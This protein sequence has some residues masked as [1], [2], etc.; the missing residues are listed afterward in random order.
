MPIDKLFSMNNDLI[1]GNKM[2][3]RNLLPL[4]LAGSMIVACGETM[5]ANDAP[6][7]AENGLETLDAKA[8]SFAVRPGSPEAEAVV[9]FANQALADNAAGTA[10]RDLLDSEMHKTAAK[11]VAKFRAG[12]DGNFGTAD[13]KTFAD[14][15]ALDKVPYVGRTALMQMLGLADAAGYLNRTSVDCANYIEHDA[16]NNYYIRS[17]AAMLE[18]ENSRCSTITGNLTIQI[19]GTDILPPSAR[20]I[21]ALQHLESVT[22]NVL[23]YPTSIFNSI[24]FKSLKTIT[25]S[26]ISTYN[27]TPMHTLEFPALTGVSYIQLTGMKKNTFA[28]LETCNEISLEN[29]AMEGFTA[30]KAAGNLTMRVTSNGAY[31]VNFP[32]LTEATNIDF[33]HQPQSSYGINIAEFNGSFAKLANVSGLSMTKGSYTDL[34]FPKLTKVEGSLNTSSAKNPYDGMTKLD[35]VN[36]LS[37]QNDEFTSLINAGPKVLTSAGQLA[38]TSR[39]AVDGFEKLKTVEGD[40]AVNANSGISGF[41]ALETVGGSVS[42]TT[43]GGASSK[44]GGFNKLS[45]LSRLTINAQNYAV[46]LEPSFAALENIE[47]YLSITNNRGFNTDIQFA[48]LLSV[49]GGVRIDQLVG[50]RDVFPQLEIIDGSLELNYAPNTF[51]GMDKLTHVEGNLSI[52]GALS[53]MNGLSKLD[54]IG[55][56]L[57][58]PRGFNGAN[59]DAFL[60][61]LTEFS[62]TITFR[63]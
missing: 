47:S 24:N 45:N 17:Y 11:N 48:R 29:N 38:I 37:S 31:A 60:N 61:Q 59:L 16:R 5:D 57:L 40:I 15:T 32:A 21:Q 6:L 49:G 8:D 34:T 27:T 46:T 4:L 52:G 43:G 28:K 12:A 39:F 63:N 53:T 10:F 58:V 2:K 54:S 33:T 7:D 19:S 25:G 1:R 22:G 20:E 42:L 35:F 36:Q 13:D 51:I 23:I 30:L 41:N 26:L 62:G 3:T 44:I 14:L 18:I 50:Q 9:A 55:S 56:N